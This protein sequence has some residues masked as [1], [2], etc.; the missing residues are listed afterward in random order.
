MVWT[1]IA[2]VAWIAFV[3]LLLAFLRG[4]TKGRDR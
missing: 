4:G 3:L 2:V 1:I